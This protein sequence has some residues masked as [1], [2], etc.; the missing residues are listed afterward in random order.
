MEGGPGRPWLLVRSFGTDPSRAVDPSG[1]LDALPEEPPTPA[2]LDVTGL[3]AGVRLVVA[4]IVPPDRTPADPRTLYLAWIPVTAVDDSRHHPAPSPSPPVTSAAR[5][6]RRH[7]RRP[8]QARP[9]RPRI[10][11]ARAGRGYLGRPS[12]AFQVASSLPAVTLVAIADQREPDQVGRPPSAG[13]AAGR[14]TR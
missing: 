6:G 3:P 13:P 8:S 9:P 2:R 14:L 4:A 5:A 12:Q 7:L 11:A 1:A 10:P